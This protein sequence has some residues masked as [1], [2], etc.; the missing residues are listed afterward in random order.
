MPRGQNLDLIGQEFGCLTVLRRGYV[1][2][3][4]GKGFSSCWECR[5]SC[6]AE[7]VVSGKIL[8]AG[9][10]KACGLNGHTWSREISDRTGGAPSDGPEYRAWQRIRQRCGNPKHHRFPHYG[11]RGIS[12][13]EAWSDYDRFFADMGERPSPLHSIERKDVNGNYEPDNCVW[14]TDKEQRR[15]KRNTVW[16]EWEGVRMKFADLMDDLGLN[17]SLVAGRLR[18]GWDIERAVSTPSRGWTRRNPV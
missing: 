14:A 4:T 13:C 5:C 18:N 1:E 3:R 11:G 17:P 10:V 7:R 12:V 16:V 8:R 9:A 6:G 2:G 15:N